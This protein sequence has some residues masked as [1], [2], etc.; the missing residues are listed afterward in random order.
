MTKP[1][2]RMRPLG[3][4]ALDAD[5]AGFFDALSHEWPIRFLEYRIGDRRAIRL[6]RKWLTAGV[7]EDGEVTATAAGTPQGAVVSPLLA[8]I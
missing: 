8:N 5:I 2:R 4:A 7:V 1:D 6:V 3:I